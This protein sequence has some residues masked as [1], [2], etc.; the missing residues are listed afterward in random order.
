MHFVYVNYSRGF[1]EGWG[2]CCRDFASDH[3]TPFC[4]SFCIDII[5]SCKKKTLFSNQINNSH[6]LKWP[7]MWFQLEGKQYRQERRLGAQ[8]LQLRQVAMRS[9]VVA[10]TENL[11]ESNYNKNHYG[12]DFIQYKNYCVKIKLFCLSLPW[13]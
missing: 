3:K 5:G 1:F 4:S 11:K 9:S 7:T 13:Y 12:F 2:Y 10:W 8:F 6:Y